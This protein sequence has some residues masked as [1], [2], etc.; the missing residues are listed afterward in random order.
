M[1]FAHRFCRI[2]GANGD[3]VA[4]YYS[5]QAAIAWVLNHH[6]Y[7][8][9]HFVWAATPFHPYREPNPKSS[10]PYLVY[11]DL[12]LPWRDD[13]QYDRFITK[14]RMDLVKGIIAIGSAIDDSLADELEEICN[15]G[16]V[17][18]FL[19]IVYRIDA[20]TLHPDR[21]DISSGSAA[22]G[23]HEILVRD[24]AETEFDILFAEDHTSDLLTKAMAPA[25][26]R[27]DLLDL[28]RST[29]A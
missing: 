2:C 17:E 24:L 14:L 13:D 16:S 1:V 12:Y 27:E 6:F 21:I 22:V 26:E 11:G 15:R 18:L 29:C 19:P 9:R 23:S 4:Y 8:G 5:T 20:S 3:Q 10:N 28:L 25:A 7:G